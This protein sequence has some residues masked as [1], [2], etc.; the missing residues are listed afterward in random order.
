MCAF[1]FNFPSPFICF[2]AQHSFFESIK[3]DVWHKRVSV[4]FLVLVSRVRK[5]DCIKLFI[6]NTNKSNKRVDPNNIQQVL[7]TGHRSGPWPWATCS[8][9]K[10]AIIYLIY[11]SY[12]CG[13]K[14]ILPV[15][16][17]WPVTYVLDP[18]VSEC[19]WQRK[20][21]QKPSSNS[22]NYLLLHVAEVIYLEFLF[23]KWRCVVIFI[24]NHDNNLR[25]WI[26]CGVSGIYACNDVKDVKI[27]CFTVNRA[28]NGNYSWNIELFEIECQSRVQKSA[29]QRTYLVVIKSCD[30]VTLC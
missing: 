9:G 28:C 18:P 27:L 20:S 8:E 6:F 5:F 10:G 11:I 25:V 22:I 30:V 2:I 7:N 16:L 19:I 15:T 3:L 24:S 21:K 4:S 12:F 1:N 29:F 17:P 23:I 14:I 26:H 13:R